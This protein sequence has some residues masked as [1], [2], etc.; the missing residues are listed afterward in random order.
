MQGMQK[1]G[2]HAPPPLPKH[3]FDDDTSELCWWMVGVAAELSGERGG[4]R[5][6]A[7]PR[8]N[9]HAT[10]CLW[11]GGVGVGVGFFCSPCFACFACL[12]ACW[13][14]LGVLLVRS[15]VVPSC[16]PRWGTRGEVTV[17]R[18]T[19]HRSAAHRIAA[20]AQAASNIPYLLS[21][22]SHRR[23]P[24][25]RSGPIRLVEARRPE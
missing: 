23:A 1:A 24:P 18:I 5:S 21:C 19:S 6:A 4:E 7:M 2:R 15:V 20:A 10:K 14:L 17:A 11:R 25:P 22:P 16:C 12:L 8:C 3:V 9:L 13:S